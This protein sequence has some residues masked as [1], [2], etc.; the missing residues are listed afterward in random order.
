LVVGTATELGGG[1]DP[2]GCRP[3]AHP[4]VRGCP[5]GGVDDHAQRLLDGEAAVAQVAGGQLRVVGQHGAHADDHRVD[6]AAVGVHVHAR[7][8]GGDPHAAAVGG[9]RAP[10]EGG[11]VLPDHV[12]AAAAD[13]G[14]PEDVAGLHLGLA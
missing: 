11:G 1:G 12:R 3:V 2:G 14:Q 6:G 4:G 9:G 10:V 5:A 7:R 13:R 8:L